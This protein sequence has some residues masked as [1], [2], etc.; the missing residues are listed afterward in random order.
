M[1]NRLSSRADS[2]QELTGSARAAVVAALARMVVAE[3][4]REQG[5]QGRGREPRKRT[6][7]GK[8]GRWN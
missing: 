6:Q 5:L 2:D 8:A 3:L 1:D 4:E 7:I